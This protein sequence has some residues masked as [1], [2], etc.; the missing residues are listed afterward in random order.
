MCAS[1]IRVRWEWLLG[2]YLAIDKVEGDL[3]GPQLGFGEL[4][5]PELLLEHE[6][7]VLVAHVDRWYLANHGRRT[8]SANEPCPHGRSDMRRKSC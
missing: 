2:G 1:A 4:V 7:E 6:L 8:A 5:E 3:V